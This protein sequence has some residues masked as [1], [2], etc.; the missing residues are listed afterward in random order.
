MIARNTRVVSLEKQDET[1]KGT[2]EEEGEQKNIYQPMKVIGPP[3]HVHPWLPNAV[4]SKQSTYD[5]L[6]IYTG[7]PIIPDDIDEEDMY[8]LFEDPTKHLKRYHT[9]QEADLRGGARIDPVRSKRKSMSLTFMALSLLSLVTIVSGTP[10]IQTIKDLPEMDV[11][12]DT[13]IIRV[14]NGSST[15]VFCRV[16]AEYGGKLSWVGINAPLPKNS[17]QNNGYLI[18]ESINQDLDLQCKVVSGFSTFQ[19]KFKLVVI[20]DTTPEEVSLPKYIEGFDCSSPLTRPIV[21]A[22]TATQDCKLDDFASYIVQ[23][24]TKFVLIG[25]DRTVKAKSKR[26]YITMEISRGICQEK[27]VSGFIKV[28]HGLYDISLLQCQE[29]HETG[30]TNLRVHKQA[31]LR[32]RRG[33]QVPEAGPDVSI[34]TIEL[35]RRHLGGRKHT[36]GQTLIFR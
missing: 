33:G 36:L 11:P 1:T 26:C 18:I 14:K 31:Y 32:D 12:Q 6:P 25:R 8:V 20:P 15:S 22:S 27:I 35:P 23:P 34:G 2:G 13:E 24:D 3:T 28:F 4:H 5:I 29:M 9:L 19:D 30:K 10:Q 17:Q 21:R 7:R 16:F